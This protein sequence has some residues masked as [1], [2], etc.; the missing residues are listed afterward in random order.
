MVGIFNS[1]DANLLK[2]R[3]LV[4]GRQNKTFVEFKPEMQV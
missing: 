3:K 2:V 4:T 1:L